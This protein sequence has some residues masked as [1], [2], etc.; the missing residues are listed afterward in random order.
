M[1]Q[2]IRKV[3]GAYKKKTKIE[4]SFLVQIQTRSTEHNSST[5]ASQKGDRNKVET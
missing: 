3:F 2:R 4:F 5:V 1:S